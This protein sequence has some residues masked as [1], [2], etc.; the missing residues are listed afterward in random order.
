[1]IGYKLKYILKGS[2]K[3]DLLKNIFD[4]NKEITE[5]DLEEIINKI[6]IKKYKIEIIEMPFGDKFR[7]TFKVNNK[8]YKAR[9]SEWKDT[10]FTKINLIK[11]LLNH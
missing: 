4:T 2:L 10:Y 5:L 8:A 6:N 11:Y 7:Y 9:I 1:M 3:F